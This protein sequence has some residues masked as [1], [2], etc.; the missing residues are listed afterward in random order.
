MKKV[1]LICLFVFCFNSITNAQSKINADSLFDV[2]ENKTL[3]EKERLDAV[4][5]FII[6][7][8]E[9]IGMVSG[10]YVLA[11]QMA[12]LEI[13]K[14]HPNYYG[15]YL[16]TK[17]VELKDN[18]Y[19]GKLGQDKV[20]MGIDSLLKSI[21]YFEDTNDNLGKVLAQ[22]FL[23]RSYVK[24]K[25]KEMAIRSYNKTLALIAE[26]NQYKVWEGMAY[27]R[28]AFLSDSI[29]I[30]QD[31]KQLF[32]KGVAILENINNQYFLS[33]AYSDFGKKL[34]KKSKYIQALEYYKK[35]ES[36]STS[37]YPRQM[38]KIYNSLGQIN[39][40]LDQFEKGLKYH[41]KSLEIAIEI[42][43]NQGIYEYLWSISYWHW[44][45][46]NIEEAFRYIDELEEKA[47]KEG[48]KYEEAWALEV[49]ADVC[50]K[51]GEFKKSIL[52]ANQ[53]LE[54]RK[55]LGHEDLLP[56]NVITI[57]EA[58][59]ALGN[60]NQAI[61]YCK[62]SLN[63]FKRIQDNVG[64]SQS[65]V[66]LYE[67]YKATGKF[68]KALSFLEK[69]IELDK[70][71][72]S[73]A[74]NKKLLEVEF[75][76]QILRDSLVRVARDIEK[77]KIFQTTITQK[78]KTRNIVIGIGGLILLLSIGLWSRLGHIRK[79]NLLLK[80]KNQIIEIEKEKAKASEQAKHQ[81]LANMSHEIRTPMN[82]IKGMTDILIR[83][84][85]KTNQKEYLDGIKQS[86][87][88][89]LIIVNDILDI[90]KIE[91]SKIELEQE[92][93]SVNELVN[94]V[95]TIMQFKTEEK[96]IVLKKDIPTRQL[97]VK[98]DATRLRQILI[99]L[100][101]NA[102]K[103]TEKGVVTTRITSE[104]KEDG[105][106]LKLHFTI[107]DTGIG[108]DKDRLEKVFKS[109]EQEYSDTSRKFGGTG[110]GLSI[111]KKLVE[112]HNG[113][114][115]VESEKGKGSQF[116]FVIPYEVAKLKKLKKLFQ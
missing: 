114:I 35:A 45:L 15:Y 100:I 111:S 51:N 83:R 71:K 64:F 5:P 76:R 56:R 105:T 98:G 102:I 4:I 61:N 80:E 34:Q 36:A 101:G 96:G 77:E 6:D 29:D 11:D 54:I 46:E 88:S 22:Y 81:F 110:L 93:F 44:K 63:E 14:S 73:K 26:T 12:K 32:D 112:L 103:F 9:N 67:S 70:S 82:A 43:D 28:T 33:K 48:N 19:T 60:Y 66:C 58:N 49:K 69:K 92:P 62:Q 50:K 75:E 99:N 41:L 68:E 13:T 52:Y 25:D 74:V 115:W 72:S 18:E 94:N 79:T 78:N 30:D 2:W 8:W 84:Q 27:V 42:E 24:K 10:R 37:E 97:I 20:D 85:P 107:S 108:I 95:H 106:T 38:M 104:E 3:P 55:A 7:N 65:C 47:L 16:L 39:G 57:G 86:S 90:S 91:A 59:V 116:H 89:L 21:P 113:K 109:F 87:D 53:S 1:L 31:A 23:G 17:G 40:D